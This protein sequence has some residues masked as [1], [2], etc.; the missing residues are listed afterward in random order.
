MTH[1]CLNSEHLAIAY[2]RSTELSCCSVHAKQSICISCIKDD[3]DCGEYLILIEDALAFR[4]YS[5]ALFNK[6]FKPE[7]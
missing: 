7:C 1:T 4:Y 3:S 2:L 5:V 6:L